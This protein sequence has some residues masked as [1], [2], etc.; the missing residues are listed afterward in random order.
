MFVKTG[1]G[2]ILNVLPLEELTEEQK[3]ALAKK[4]EENKDK[5]E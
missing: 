5:K 1:D 3:K 2:K 4:E